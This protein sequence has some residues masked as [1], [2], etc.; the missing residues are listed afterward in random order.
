MQSS[1]FYL[2]DHFASRLSTSVR[3]GV[4]LPILFTVMM[5]RSDES[6]ELPSTQE[7]YAANVKIF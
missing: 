4:K 1:N 5:A 3:E 6:A 2:G 7:E